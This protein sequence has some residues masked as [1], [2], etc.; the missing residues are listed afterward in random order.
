MRDHRKL[1]TFDIA[2]ELAL[3]IYRAT[4]DFPR[5]EVFGLK[6]QMREAAVSIPSNI[7]EGCARRTE[8]EYLRFLEFAFGSAQELSYQISLAERLGPF[9]P[10]DVPRLVRLS[11]EACKALN[12]QIRGLKT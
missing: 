6:D 12:G 2:D 10:N 7:V 5:T 11:T 3:A 4:A 9:N 8:R 1:K